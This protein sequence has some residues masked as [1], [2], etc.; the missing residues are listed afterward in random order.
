MSPIS[1]PIRALEGS[2]NCEPVVGIASA[3]EFLLTNKK[4]PQNFIYG[5]L[6]SGGQLSFIIENLPKDGTGCPGWW[7]FEL[8]MHHFGSNVTA[9]QGNWTYGDNLATVNRLTAGGVM[10][11]EE[12]ARQGPTGRYAVAWGFNQVQVLPQI[13]GAPGNYSRVYVL[14]KR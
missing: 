8:M 2:V 11:I 14:F 13:T 1:L 3:T 9:I 10:T 12:A 7:M 4:K 6:I 5:E